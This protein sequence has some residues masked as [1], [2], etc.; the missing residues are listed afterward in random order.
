MGTLTA[1]SASLRA[2]IATHRAAVDGVLA[3][4]AAINPRL[5]GSVSRG[6]ATSASDIDLLVDLLPEGGN[7]LLRVAGIAE[8]LSDLLGTRVDVVAES[9]LRRE[10]SATALA[11]SV[12]V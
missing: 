5:S 2:A 8:E 10:V 9:L 11:D 4:Y 1:E 6:D 12:A 3:R 7:E